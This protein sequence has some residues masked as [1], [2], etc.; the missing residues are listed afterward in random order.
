MS[1]GTF[2]SKAMLRR[3]YGRQ[4]RTA[5]ADASGIAILDFGRPP[6]GTA[7]VVIGIFVRSDAGATVRLFVGSDPGTVD[8]LAEVDAVSANPAVSRPDEIFVDSGEPIWV[9]VEGVAPGTLCSGQIR[10]RILQVL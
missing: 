6:G 8:L 4:A 9:Q 3:K 1:V 10:Y 2:P 7:W 5:V